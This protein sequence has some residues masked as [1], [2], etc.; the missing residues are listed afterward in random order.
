MELDELKQFHGA[1]FDEAR[2][3]VRTLEERLLELETHPGDAELLGALFRAAHSIKGASGILGFDTITQLTHAMENVLDAMRE[4]RLATSPALTSLL[5]ESTDLLG[6]CVECAAGE[7]PAP[8]IAEVVARLDATA[9][10]EGSAA[11][12]P[13]EQDEAQGTR[14]WTVI[15]RPRPD[16]FAFGINPALV[17]R[18]LTLVGQ[19][20]VDVLLDAVP[21]FEELDPERCSL[22][23]RITLVTDATE[24]RIREVFMF[25]EDMCDL[26]LS[27][28]HE[29]GFSALPSAAPLPPAPPQA[30]APRAVEPQAS[31]PR[32]Q[33][34]RAS[35]PL[36]SAPRPSHPDAA[37]A[38]APSAPGGEHGHKGSTDASTLR[39]T[40][41]KVDRLV[42]LVG[43]LV[44]SQAMISRCMQDVA[45]AQLQKLR[46]AVE[47]METHTRDLQESVMNI[48]MVPI[49]S[50]FGRFR[51]LVRDLSATLGKDIQLETVGEDTELDKSMVESLADPLTHLVRNSADHGIERTEERLAAGKPAAGRVVLSARHQGGNVVVDITDDGRG[52]DTER[53]RAKAVERG[54][55]ADHA[56]LSTEQIHELIFAPGFSTAATVTG[57]SGR[58]VGMD[59]VKRSVEALN[60]SV[61]LSSTPG[62]G[63]RFRLTLPLTL[64][65]LD[66]MALRVGAATFVLPLNQVV[67]TLSMHKSKAVKQ[68]LSS[69][70]IILVRGE[71]L[72]LVR[73]GRL[74]GVEDDGAQN[75]RPLAVVL[76]VGDVRF[77]MMVDELLGKSQYVI[78]NLEPNF[79]K[80]DG[81]LGATILGDGT[82]SLI[83]DVQALAR[84]GNVRS[85]E[86]RE[87]IMAASSSRREAT[88]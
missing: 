25:V 62:E 18:E 83:L 40:T 85:R 57:L 69:G 1:F 3:H 70:E 72:P 17:L 39:V 37:L 24:K 71:T 82:V 63:S 34:P 47:A 28:S 77:G 9:P 51:R 84:M 46:E 15:F 30:S 60:G 75:A 55:I 10:R 21:P 6:T 8:A 52:L 27:W 42:N 7:R 86:D 53:I 16:C 59:V 49:G 35:A 38:P 50:I 11:A 26:E 41:E 32:P 29:P 22:G 66:G 14:R 87:S 5:L 81:L 4:N 54:I 79:Q 23:W 2:D 65:I 58:G 80:L 56:Q 73:L 61:A 36:A 19:A 33:E 88:A 64:A 20:E 44:I 68:L 12:S 76:E 13:A 43:E 31:A 78:K 74:L 45:G 48:R 67:E